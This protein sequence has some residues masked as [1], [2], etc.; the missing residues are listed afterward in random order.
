MVSTLPGVKADCWRTQHVDCSTAALTA[1][2]LAQHKSDRGAV[3]AM[4]AS[5]WQTQTAAACAYLGS[6]GLKD[7]LDQRLFDW[8]HLR[9]LGLELRGMKQR[10]KSKTAHAAVLNMSVMYMLDSC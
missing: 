10:Q 4:P 1:H 6:V 2:T 5:Q 7:V 3:A 9:E 8:Q